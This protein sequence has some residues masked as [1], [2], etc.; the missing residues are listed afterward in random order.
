MRMLLLGA[1]I[2]GVTA[3]SAWAAPRTYAVPDPTAQLR[4]PKADSLAAGYEAAQANCQTC[5]SVDYIAT[6]PPG[7]GKAFWDAEVSKM[8]KAYHAPIEQADAGAIAAYL[9]D[10][11]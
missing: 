8:I 2:G 3:G 5:H 11:Y 1:M 7:R 9:A 10:T 6:Q 4:P